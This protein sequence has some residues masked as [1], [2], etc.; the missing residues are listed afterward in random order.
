MR[1]K[2]PPIGT[3][4]LDASCPPVRLYLRTWQR[5]SGIHESFVAIARMGVHKRRCRHLNQRPGGSRPLFT[6]GSRG[7]VG[8]VSAADHSLPEP[9]KPKQKKT[10]K[11]NGGGGDPSK[12]LSI[13]PYHAYAGPNLTAF[14]LHHKTHWKLL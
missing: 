2:A 11:K 7:G 3:L 6:R 4:R 10:K 9:P 8:W 12:P 13:R 5:K 14:G 1:P